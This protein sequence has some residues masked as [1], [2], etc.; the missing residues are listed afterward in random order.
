MLAK[1]ASTKSWLVQVSPNDWRT[2]VTPAALIFWASAMNSSQVAGGVVMP[3]FSKTL[4]LY[5][6]P[7]END[8]PHGPP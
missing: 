7:P 4:V 2:G 3:A 6:M 1:S 8:V 5:M